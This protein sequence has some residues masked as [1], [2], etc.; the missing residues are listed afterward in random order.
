VPSLNVHL[1]LLL[2]AGGRAPPVE[3]LPE[4]EETYARLE[5]LEHEYME[6]TEQGT[7]QAAELWFQG[8]QELL[9]TVE[10]LGQE[11]S[12][13]A[14][15][16]K[17]LE[18]AV[19]QKARP[20]DIWGHFRR[21]FDFMW[22]TGRLTETPSQSPDYLRGRSLYASLC[23]VC[24]GPR[25]VLREAQVKHLDP[26][27]SDFLDPDVMNPMSPLHAYYMIVYGEHGTSMPSFRSL[28]AEDVW[29]I[30]FYLFT[31]RLEPCA[32]KPLH[33]PLKRLARSSDNNLAASYT[34]GAL[35]CLRWPALSR[36]P[37]SSTK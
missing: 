12:P 17:A 15:E 6:M 19:R 25:G 3:P 9:P 24:H 10:R 23:S 22:S 4:W 29:A 13:L 30:A 5:Q 33:V 27:P 36:L 37:A 2:L 28:A 26:A 21:A 7:D 32:S 35:P 8:L 14:R 1:L 20:M 11:G 34:D 16:L 31:L 18:Q